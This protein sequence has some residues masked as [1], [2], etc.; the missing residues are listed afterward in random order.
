MKIVIIGG[1]GLIGS[2][3]VPK[4][5]EHGHEA[6]GAGLVAVVVGEGVAGLRDRP[7]REHLGPAEGAAGHEHLAARIR[8]FIDF[9]RSF[10]RP[11]TP[12]SQTEAQDERLLD[13]G[14]AG[15]GLIIT[16]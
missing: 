8:A 3:L 6:I 14:E 5:R 12:G 15:G 1:T 9:L 7:L 4:L 16:P 10:F 2:K 11:G 13:P